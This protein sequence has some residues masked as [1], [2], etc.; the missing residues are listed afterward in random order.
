[1]KQTYYFHLFLAQIKESDF[2]AYHSYIF[3]KETNNPLFFKELNIKDY[4]PKIT[5][6]YGLE[7]LNPD[8]RYEFPLSE[9]LKFTL[10][11]KENLPIM[12][13]LCEQK[14]ISPNSYIILYRKGLQIPKEVL[15]SFP[16]L[17]YFGEFEMDNNALISKKL[18][19][20]HLF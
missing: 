5:D 4:T 8:F 13:A 11:K 2:E 9:L 10:L 19:Y 18:A 1:M 7:V 14:G 17:Y 6:N 20:P 3:D 16:N 12:E 15:L